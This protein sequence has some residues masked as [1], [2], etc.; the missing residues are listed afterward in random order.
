[1]FICGTLEMEHIVKK[2]RIKL[3]QQIVSLAM[4]KTQLSAVVQFFS[5]VWDSVGSASTNFAHS[6]SEVMAGR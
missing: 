5:R 4:Q 3:Q 6:E 2:P 1:M